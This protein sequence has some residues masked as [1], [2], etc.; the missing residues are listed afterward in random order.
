MFLLIVTATIFF[1]AFDNPLT[2]AD[3]FLETENVLL[4]PTTFVVAA[5]AVIGA[6]IERKMAE[7]GV[8]W[9]FLRK[10]EKTGMLT[11]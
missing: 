8:K 4:T 7:M 6:V 5:S 11:E 10:I 1:S 2:F 3:A 9:G